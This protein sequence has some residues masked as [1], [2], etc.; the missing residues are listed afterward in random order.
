MKYIIVFS[1]LL[2]LFSSC[3]NEETF[4]KLKLT[5]IVLS[6]FVD[7]SSLVTWDS[8]NGPDIFITVTLNDSIIFVSDRFENMDVL[9]APV[10][11]RINSDI[12]FK[13]VIDRIYLT[14]YDADTIDDQIMENYITLQPGLSRG[15]PFSE[16][17]SCGSCLAEWYLTYE[18]LE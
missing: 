8:F 17:I 6:K 11:F 16:Y 1:W 3:S 14:A 12:A 18:I 4:R 13:G 7:T 5:E 2:I 9:G 10:K 15:S